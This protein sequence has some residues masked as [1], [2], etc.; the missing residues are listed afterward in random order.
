MVRDEVAWELVRDEW[1]LLLT[2]GTGPTPLAAL[3]EALG[4]EDG[5]IQGRVQVLVR[6]G[7]VRATPAGFELVQAFYERRE[8]MSTYLRDL[9]LRRVAEGNVVPTS[10]RVRFDVGGRADIASLVQDAHQK[11]FPEVVD[12]A[13]QPES[14]SSERFSVFF[15]ASPDA[16]EPKTRELIPSFLDVLGCAASERTRDPGGDAACLWIAEM[17]TDPR[18]ADAIGDLLDKFLT[19][20]PAKHG[21]AA[22][23]FAIVPTGRSARLS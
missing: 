2:I 20:A 17:K 6:Y 12:L 14:A 13:S 1:D 9:V 8:G 15:V 22:A 21:P 7:L 10:G 4:D 3:I 16:G 11:L 19:D 23:G 5:S 18:V